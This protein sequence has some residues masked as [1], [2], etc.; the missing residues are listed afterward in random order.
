MKQHIRTALMIFLVMG[1]AACFPVT[2]ATQE[3]VASPQPEASYSFY[4]LP[5]QTG[6]EDIDTILE[7]LADDDAEE[8][9][10]LIQFTDA[11][12]TRADGFGG[13]PK[14]RAGE[15]EG[16]PV[17]VLPF[18]G[19]EGSFLRRDEISNWQGIDAVGLYAIYQVSPA[20]SFEQYYPAGEYAIMLVGKEDRS[21]VVLRVEAGR[22]VR[23]DYLPGATLESLKT[24]LRSEA[25]T[26]ILEPV[27]R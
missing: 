21:P 23:V 17:E 1:M 20:V 15:A 5:A 25:G 14:C 6:L 13:P 12:C 22:I 8:L 9:Y 26:V 19:S 7:A 27:D 18:L 3:A 10:S 4:P 2:P 16:T 11:E 24:T